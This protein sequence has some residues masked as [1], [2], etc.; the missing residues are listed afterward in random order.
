MLFVDCCEGKVQ[1]DTILFMWRVRSV[2]QQ[3]NSK[4]YLSNLI[5]A[6]GYKDYLLALSALHIA[7]CGRSMNI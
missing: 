7:G 2:E 6:K 3:L 4:Q 1:D 5:E